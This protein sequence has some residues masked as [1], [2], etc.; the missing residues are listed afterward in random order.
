MHAC[1]PWWEGRTGGGDG[2]YTESRGPLELI[3]LTLQDALVV[4]VVVVRPSVC[5]LLLPV[6]TDCVQRCSF[7][8][9]KNEG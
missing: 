8:Q 7:L 6:L 2:Q 9:D 3:I 1:G 4:D 5:V